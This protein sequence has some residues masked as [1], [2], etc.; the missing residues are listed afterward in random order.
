MNWELI[1]AVAGGIVLIANAGSAILKAV[2]PAIKAKE[3]LEELDRRT[4]NDYDAINE[5]KDA[6]LR[7]EEV[8]RLQIVVMLDIL[9]HLIDGNDVEEMKETRRQLQ[10]LLANKE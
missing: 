2:S 6:I 4:R 1:L 10:K 8:N 7:N 5:L 9:N 3:E